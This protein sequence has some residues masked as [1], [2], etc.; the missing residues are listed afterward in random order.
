MC[1]A[2]C[3]NSAAEVRG[4]NDKQMLAMIDAQLMDCC[5]PTTA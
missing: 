2:T 3:R 1:A 4:W 5:T